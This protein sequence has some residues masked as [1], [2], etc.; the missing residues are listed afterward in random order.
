MHSIK[1]N[2]LQ[3]SENQ[4]GALRSCRPRAAPPALVRPHCANE[5]QK[6]SCGVRSMSIGR[7]WRGSR[8]HA[9]C[10]APGPNSSPDREGGGHRRSSQSQPIKRFMAQGAM[11]LAMPCLP[12][13]CVSTSRALAAPL[14]FR[15]E[16]PALSAWHEMPGQASPRRRCLQGQFSAGPCRVMG[17]PRGVLRGGA[18][19]DLMVPGCAL[20]AAAH[21][22]YRPEPKPGRV[23]HVQPDSAFPGR[24]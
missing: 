20:V 16:G 15:P 10:N 23:N 24:G 5:S 8:C 22:R 18:M 13:G 3:F 2:P 14:R 9:V 17:G 6:T 7:S 21:L 1:K 19:V 11:H 4:R 12:H